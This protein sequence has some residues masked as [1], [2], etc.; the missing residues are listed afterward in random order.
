M[1][2]VELDG[3]QN[4]EPEA[5]AADE[6]RSAELRR[7]G[8]HVLRFTDREAPVEREGVLTLILNWLQLHHPHPSPLPPAGEGA[9]LP[10]LRVD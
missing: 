7:L 8:F 3:G 10:R 6:R 4:F 2:I 5:M 9:F 1:L